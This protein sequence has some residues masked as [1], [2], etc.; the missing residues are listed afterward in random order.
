MTPNS[1]QL[2]PLLQAT[3]HLCLH[4]F[5]RFVVSISA[6]GEMVL[7]C[8]SH[9]QLG[10]FEASALNKYFEILSTLLSYLACIA[11][12]FQCGSCLKVNKAHSFSVCN[13][14]VYQLGGRNH[15]GGVGTGVNHTSLS[16]INGM[17]SRVS[18][19]C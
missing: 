15:L 12:F 18:M 14:L 9:L 3:K 1:K 2:P 13:S 16:P 7:T 5:W 19:F 11:D 10:G 8:A 6:L 4:G 17:A